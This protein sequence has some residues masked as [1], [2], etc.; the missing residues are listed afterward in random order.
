M[1]MVQVSI[2]KCLKMF[3]ERAAMA[4]ITEFK[5][6]HKK[7]VLKPMHMNTVTNEER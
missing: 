4:N 5:Q 7:T 3:G 1:I 2:K 6:L